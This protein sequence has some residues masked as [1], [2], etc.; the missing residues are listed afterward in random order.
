MPLGLIV[1]ADDDTLTR[2]SNAGT[3][4]IEHGLLAVASLLLLGLIVK[5]DD[6]TLTRASNAG[7]TSRPACEDD[8]HFLALDLKVLLANEGVLNATE[9]DSAGVTPLDTIRDD[10]PENVRLVDVH[11]LLLVI[12]DDDLSLLWLC[13]DMLPLVAQV[14]MRSRSIN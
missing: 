4:E 2:A 1:K 3:T 5:A 14:G 12:T 13:V 7:T 9:P 11:L 8:L 6:D 10:L